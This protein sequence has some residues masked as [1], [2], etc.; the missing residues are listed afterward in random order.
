MSKK[1]CI[2]IVDYNTGKKKWPLNFLFSGKSDQPQHT[3]FVSKSQEKVTV[4]STQA[5]PPSPGQNVRFSL[6]A[7]DSFI[8]DTGM[9]LRTNFL[10]SY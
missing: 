6:V 4:V 5:R 9:F 2:S 10:I 3:S 7:G 1:D 8:Q